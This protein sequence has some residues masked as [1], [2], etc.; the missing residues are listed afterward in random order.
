[1]VFI[2][3]SIVLNLTAIASTTTVDPTIVDLE[4]A[5]VY[6]YK[7]ENGVISFT[8]NINSIPKSLRD[9]ADVTQQKRSKA[10]NDKATTL[11][12]YFQDTVKSIKNYI[13]NSLKNPLVIGLLIIIVILLLWCLKLWIKNVIF[14]F[15]S[16]I[17]IRVAICALLYI[18]G[19]YLYQEAFPVNPIKK[20]EENIEQFQQKQKEIKQGLDAVELDP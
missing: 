18:L 19:H 12:K 2:I 11:K 14:K 10:S 6:R 13:Q 15:I 20:T 5:G 17:A 7:D 8:D 9:Q 4:K 16:R 1:M 3:I